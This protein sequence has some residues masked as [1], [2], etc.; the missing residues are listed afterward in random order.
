MQ[1][2][3]CVLINKD[4][5]SSVISIADLNNNYKKIKEKGK[6]EFV[7]V[8]IS[9]YSEAYA[10]IPTVY[11]P[12][13][14]SPTTIKYTLSVKI[15]RGRHNVFEE[16]PNDKMVYSNDYTVQCNFLYDLYVFFFSIYKLEAFNVLNNMSEI[17]INSIT[18]QLLF[19]DQLPYIF[20]I[21]KIELQNKNIH[22]TQ[23]NISGLENIQTIIS[24]AFKLDYLIPP[25][26]FKIWVGAHGACSFTPYNDI[27]SM[28][29]VVNRVS[30]TCLMSQNCIHYNAC[31]FISTRDEI[32]LKGIAGGEML[33]VNYDLMCPEEDIAEYFD[34]MLNVN[35]MLKH[36]EAVSVYRVEK[37][38]LYTMTDLV[39]AL[40][41]AIDLIQT[42]DI[43][44]K[45]IGGDEASS[46]TMFEIRAWL[47]DDFC[48]KRD[49]K[50][51]ENKFSYTITKSSIEFGEVTN[52]VSDFLNKFDMYMD[53]RIPF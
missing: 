21:D 42:M 10:V 49:G 45:I 16:M 8:P 29:G 11:L 18:D 7:L 51:I 20:F 39:E 35:D 5:H 47:A 38:D 19:K 43:A 52:I 30:H 37:Y 36:P 12:D 33:L 15:L 46:E 28:T 17:K 13:N 53:S 4:F 1:E 48:R 41:F 23:N 27:K 50:I 24:D 25:N 34:K 22:I 6:S 14:F 2:K 3:K 44:K 40:T 31:S 32:N 26:L 9:L